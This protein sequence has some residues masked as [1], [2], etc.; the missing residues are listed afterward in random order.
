[1]QDL[2]F[3]LQFL[4]LGSLWLILTSRNQLGVMK[5]YLTGFWKNVSTNLCRFSQQSLTNHLLTVRYLI[6]AAQPQA[7]VQCLLAA[8]DDSEIMECVTS[9]GSSL[10]AMLITA[11]KCWWSGS[12]FTQ[13]SNNWKL[14]WSDISITQPAGIQATFSPHAK[15]SVNVH[16]VCNNCGLG[17]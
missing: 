17:G 12:K 10:P 2:T 1:M 3:R 14:C 13:C 9:E 4:V 5:I 7:M 15:L 16:Q 8:I 6:V 11:L